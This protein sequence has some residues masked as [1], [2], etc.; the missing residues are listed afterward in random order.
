M[1]ASKLEHEPMP[2]M[3]VHTQSFLQNMCTL[4]W[5]RYSRMAVA[6]FRRIMLPDKTQK[7]FKHGIRSSPTSLRIKSSQ[8]TPATIFNKFADYFW[9]WTKNN[10]G[11]QKQKVT[12]VGRHWII[13]NVWATQCSARYFYQSLFYND[14]ALMLQ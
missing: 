7:L 3:F 14:L 6:S 1:W 13:D 8:H 10:Y 2:P 9:Y 12:E 5:K 11:S 4:S